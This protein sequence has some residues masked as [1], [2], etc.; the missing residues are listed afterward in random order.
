MIVAGPHF[1]PDLHRQRE[2]WGWQREA[3]TV[4]TEILARHGA[5]AR[6]HHDKEGAV[7]A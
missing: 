2:R 6:K 1:Y 5:V 4:L 7:S 3:V